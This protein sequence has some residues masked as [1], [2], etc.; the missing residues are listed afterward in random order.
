M[1]ESLTAYLALNKFSDRSNTAKK[2][3]VIHCIDSTLAV[4]LEVLVGTPR[5]SRR[6]DDHQ[7]FTCGR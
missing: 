7:S 3:R 2:I 5:K 1:R 6:V 4:E